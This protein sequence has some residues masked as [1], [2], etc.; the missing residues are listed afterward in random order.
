MDG[1][2]GLSAVMDVELA[3]EK[4]EREGSEDFGSIDRKG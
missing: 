3:D 2:N 4:E 1:L